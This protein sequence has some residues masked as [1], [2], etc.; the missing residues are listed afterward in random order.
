M[1]GHLCVTDGLFPQCPSLCLCRL[2][3]FFCLFVFFLFLVEDFYL[4]V[5]YVNFNVIVNHCV[6]FG[7]DGGQNCCVSLGDTC[8]FLKML[9]TVYVQEKLVDVKNELFELALMDKRKRDQPPHDP[10]SGDEPQPE[11]PKSSADCQ[12]HPGGIKLDEL[13]IGALESAFHAMVSRRVLCCCNVVSGHPRRGH[14]G[15]L[16]FMME[17]ADHGDITPL[18]GVAGKSCNQSFALWNSKLLP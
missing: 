4:N 17:D 12:L 10:S 11:S 6:S 14:H 5:N 18:A 13:I 16:F 3:L 2:C 1:E 15:Q 8:G 9:I 7:E